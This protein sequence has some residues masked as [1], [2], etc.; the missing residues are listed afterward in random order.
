MLIQ[1]EISPWFFLVPYSKQRKHLF[2]NFWLLI[3]VTIM[4]YFKL[5]FHCCNSALGLKIVWRVLIYFGLF[6][7]FLPLSVSFSVV[8]CSQTSPPPRP[9]CIFLASLQVLW[10][11]VGDRRRLWHVK[12]SFLYIPHTG[13]YL[14]N[15][16]FSSEENFQVENMKP[17]EKECGRVVKLLPNASVS[18]R[19]SSVWVIQRRKIIM[20]F[21]FILA[22]WTQ[23][24]FLRHHLPVIL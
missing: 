15:A 11:A 1:F 16:I 9:I 17:K 8:A 19:N 7:G 23:K 4:F 18:H 10:E 13:A 20:D 24:I 22:T 12:H 2:H 5:S 14:P 6:S 3:N 21:C